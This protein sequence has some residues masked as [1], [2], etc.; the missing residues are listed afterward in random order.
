MR[1]VVRSEGERGRRGEACCG[2]E[3]RV[4]TGRCCR[5][6]EVPVEVEV[7]VE[8]IVAGGYLRC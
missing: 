8:H 6:V 7:E 2:I 3:G 1:A 4:Y 5:V